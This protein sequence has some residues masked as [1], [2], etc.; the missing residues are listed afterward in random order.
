MREEKIIEFI[1]SLSGVGED[2]RP[3]A[4]VEMIACG[5]DCPACCKNALPNPIARTEDAL[6]DVYSDGKGDVVIS[7]L[8]PLYALQDNFDLFDCLCCDFADAGLRHA[9][10]GIKQSINLC[11]VIRN[12]N[13]IM[14]KMIANIDTAIISNKMSKTIILFCQEKNMELVNVK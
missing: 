13:N 11:V 3:K 1:N 6:V 4:I 10:Y 5:S 7:L 12:R 14:K 2:L 9:L 8:F